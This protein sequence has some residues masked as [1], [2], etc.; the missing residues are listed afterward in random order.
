MED[1]ADKFYCENC[2]DMLKLFQK[3]VDSGIRS[4]FNPIPSNNDFAE[5]VQK[6]FHSSTI[7]RAVEY[8]YSGGGRY[9]FYLFRS[10]D[11]IIHNIWTHD[12]TFNV[13]M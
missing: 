6:Q 7:H 10:K 1:H 9:T 4:S 12:G 2:D 8:G 3:A 11:G 5:D 13:M